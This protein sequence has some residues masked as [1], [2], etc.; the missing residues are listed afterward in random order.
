LDIRKRRSLFE[1]GAFFLGIVVR[2]EGI[3]TMKQKRVFNPLAI[4]L[5][6]SAVFFAVFL[7]I[8]GMMFL[9]KS[10]RGP[11]GTSGSSSFFSSGA[12]GVVEINGVI[13]DSKKTLR[14]LERFEEESQIKAVVL[15]LNSPGGSVAPSQEIYEYVKHYKKP[16]VVSM[17]SV[18]ASGAYYI[19][20]GAKKIFAN[21]GTITG[22]IGV[23]MEFANL[24]KLYDWAKVQRYSLKTGKYK[25]AGADYRSMQPEEK[26]LLQSMI[27]DVLIQFK[28]AVSTGRNLTLNE[29]SAIAD[30]RI[31][32]GNQAK[33]AHLVDE[34]GTI[35]DAIDEA[36]QLGQ[37]KGK[38]HVIYAEKQKKG[39]LDLV[40]DS[41][42]SSVN[43]SSQSL[44]VSG[45]TVLSLI[46]AIGQVVGK[47]SGE[48]RSMPGVYWI[49]N[50]A[51]ISE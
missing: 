3:T 27:D 7:T 23:I 33:A 37:I 17:G 16:I 46:S 42:D 15:R 9:Y 38:P 44:G 30:G 1:D 34:L 48:S 4:V 32:S 26:A 40:L 31:L 11:Q 39:L 49:W 29:V 43:E 47:S 13:M 19:A 24:E 6:L 35:R 50:G 12:V 2:D 25:D 22:S 10:S 20:C 51:G 45:K 14:R 5:I 18:A 8:S 21:P 28:Q 41:D 36:A